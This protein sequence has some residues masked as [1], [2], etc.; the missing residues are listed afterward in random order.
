MNI[1][2]IGFMGCGKT[3]VGQ[4]LASHLKRDF[5]DIDGEIENNAGMT[6]S[7][8]FE[9][10]SEGH[11]R[12]LEKTTILRV[13]KL[14]NVVIATGGGAILDEENKMA[15]K[16]NGKVVYLTWAF[17]DLWQYIENCSKRPL[18]KNKSKD[19]IEA[20][21]NERKKHYSKAADFSINCTPE[22]YNNLDHFIKLIVTCY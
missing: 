1:I 7:Q 12:Q 19:E 11:F 16:E 4:R 6:I 8:I 18:L 9:K 13:S 5:Y 17:N 20:L 21:F 15:L 14:D 2:L 3:I 10:H 22:T